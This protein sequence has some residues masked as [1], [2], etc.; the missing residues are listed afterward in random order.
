MEI[1]GQKRKQ[2]Q[3]HT[4]LTSYGDDFEKWTVWITIKVLNSE[5]RA[6]AP[7]IWF[8]TRKK[9]T[10][11]SIKRKVEFVESTTIASTSKFV[12]FANSWIFIWLFYVFKLLTRHWRRTIEFPQF[13]IDVKMIYAVLFFVV[14][15]NCVASKSMLNSL[16]YYEYSALC[17][18]L[19]IFF[20]V[21]SV[22]SRLTTSMVMFS[23]LNAIAL[24]KNQVKRALLLL[25]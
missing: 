6:V 15:Q 21:Y 3:C 23:N 12:T 8:V 19:L 1:I 9:E 5:S 13:V 22:I 17:S 25:L 18:V 7:K 14:C 11:T 24:V 16:Y 4:Y 10:A 20:C 2:F